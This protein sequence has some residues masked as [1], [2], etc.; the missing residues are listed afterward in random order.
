MQH[1]N[2]CHYFFIFSLRAADLLFMKDMR[3]I[4]IGLAADLL[5]SPPSYMAVFNAGYKV[6]MSII[7]H[8]YD[9]Q[10]R[11]IIARAWLSRPPPRAAVRF[12]SIVNFLAR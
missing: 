11:R 6:G 12:Q 7:S 2:F 1:L 5:F 8:H 9:Y 4:F 10:R 3:G